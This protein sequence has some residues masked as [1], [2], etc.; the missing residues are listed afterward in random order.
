ME[1]RNIESFLT[2]FETVR[3]RTLRA[4]RAVPPGKLGGAMS[5]MFFRAAIWRATFA[6]SLGF[7]DVKVLFA[8]L[9]QSRTL[10]TSG[11]VRSEGPQSCPGP[12]P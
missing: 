8:R 2:Y 4:L 5:T 7:S 3:E 12:G 11:I 10:A 9:I 6:M 1:I